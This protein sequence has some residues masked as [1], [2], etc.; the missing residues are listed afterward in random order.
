[1]KKNLTNPTAEIRVIPKTQ[2]I[3]L[4]DNKVARLLTPT[5]RPSGD[6]YNLRIDGRTRQFTL[7]AIKSIIEGADPAT[8]GNK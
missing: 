3:L 7:E 2:Y 6:N 5:V 4:P 1:M 8:V